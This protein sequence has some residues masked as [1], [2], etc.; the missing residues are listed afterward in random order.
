M[1][2]ISRNAENIPLRALIMRKIER[3][4]ITEL[5]EKL[6][7]SAFR[8]GLILKGYSDHLPIQFSSR[9]F[10]AISWNLLADTHL[11][12][13]FTNV[14]G[15]AMVANALRQQFPDGNPYFDRIYHF[16]AELA[17]YLFSKIKT[18]SIEIDEKLLKGFI[19]LKACPSRLVCA[20]DSAEAKAVESARDYLI[21]LFSNKNA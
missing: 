4:R 3:S 19:Y 14:T 1:L 8:Y 18:D 20:G 5:E 7:S 6:Q 13:N 16:F 21:S 11:Y 15:S 9:K 10:T 2:L 17:Q 12:R